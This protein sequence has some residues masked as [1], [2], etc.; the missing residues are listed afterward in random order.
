MRRKV[1]AHEELAELQNNF[2]GRARSDAE[3]P[4]TEALSCRLQHLQSTA[5]YGQRMLTKVVDL[6]ERYD[7]AKACFAAEVVPR[8]AAPATA[9]EVDEALQT[10]AAQREGGF[11]SRSRMR[12]SRPSV[13]RQFHMPRLSWSEP[14]GGALRSLEVHGW[15]HCDYNH[16]HCDGHHRQDQYRPHSHRSQHHPNAAPPALA[17]APASAPGVSISISIVILILI[18][19]LISNLMLM[20]ILIIMIIIIIITTIIISSTIIVII[21]VTTIVILKFIVIVII[22]IIIIIIIAIVIIVII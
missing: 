15:G 5:T 10:L 11:S 9:V 4:C 8:F 3:A 2:S 12:R 21:I 17:P 14:L 7:A 18:L 19:I 16:Q 22:V 1:A 13:R 20:L 6:L